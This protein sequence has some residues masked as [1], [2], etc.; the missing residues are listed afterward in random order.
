VTVPCVSLE[1]QRLFHSG[2]ELRN[3]DLLDLAQL[4]RLE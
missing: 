3:V 1:A 4:D 2:Y